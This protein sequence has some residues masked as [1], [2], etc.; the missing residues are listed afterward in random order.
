[1][2]PDTGIV[3]EPEVLPEDVYPFSLV[4]QGEV[5]GSCASFHTRTKIGMNN[6]CFLGLRLGIE[7]VCSS[8][9]RP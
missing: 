5:K 8:L 7:P 3:V 4:E 9:L 6:S 1:M 2:D